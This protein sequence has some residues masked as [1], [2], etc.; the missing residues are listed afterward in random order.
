MKAIKTVFTL[1]VFILSSGCTIDTISPTRLSGSLQQKTNK[2]ESDKQNIEQKPKKVSTGKFHIHSAQLLLSNDKNINNLLAYA[3]VESN[4]TSNNK[5][6]SSIIK[7]QFGDAFRQPSV[8]GNPFQDDRAKQSYE[9]AVETA[10]DS[11]IKNYYSKIEGEKVV[12]NL[13]AKIDTY[14]FKANKM[15]LSF[16]NEISD[17]SSKE[18]NT[19]TWNTRDVPHLSLDSHI[20]SNNRFPLGKEKYLSMIRDTVTKAGHRL[21]VIPNSFGPIE[22]WKKCINI[23]IGLDNIPKQI[24]VSPKDAELLVADNMYPYKEFASNISTSV[25]ILQATGKLSSKFIPTS[26][27]SA[28]GFNTGIDNITFE[29]FPENIQIKHLNTGY[30]LHEVN[31]AAP[32]ASKAKKQ[33]LGPEYK[34]Y[35]AGVSFSPKDDKVWLYVHKTKKRTLFNISS[36]NQDKAFMYNLKEGDMVKIYSKGQGRKRVWSD[37]IEKY[38]GIADG[39]DPEER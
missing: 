7:K 30:V 21:T 9:A 8:T 15:I 4:K 37:V 22:K 18:M 35:T 14:D 39:F 38:Y 16:Y 12:I 31:V 32:P 19:R 2:P 20:I 27:A 17:G 26:G 25:V 28:L 6:L 3:Y 24:S 34:A 5:I 33:S 29:F 1:I 10:F 23:S 11:F 13:I 36:F